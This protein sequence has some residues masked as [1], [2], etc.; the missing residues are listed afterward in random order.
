MLEYLRLIKEGSFPGADRVWQ[1]HEP[2]IL[3]G[4]VAAGIAVVYFILKRK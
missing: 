1:G 3:I 4:V 2:L